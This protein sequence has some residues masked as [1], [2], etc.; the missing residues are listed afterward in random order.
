MFF[1]KFISNLNS[2][3]IHFYPFDAFIY[4]K[5]NFKN[6]YKKTNTLYTINIYNK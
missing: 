1:Y 6:E 4:I 3:K 5:V 2:I